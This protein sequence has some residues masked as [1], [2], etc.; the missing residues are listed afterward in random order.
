M[1][2]DER[3]IKYIEN[4]LTSEERIAFELDLG[5]SLELRE[6]FEKY[7]R[8][9]KETDELNG[10]KLNPLYLDSIIPEFRNKLET[11]KSVSIKRNLGYAFGVMLVFIISI[12]VLNDFLNDEGELTE[13]EEFTQSLN[14]NQKIELLEEINLESNDYNIISENI[15]DKELVDILATDMEI[16]SEVA[17]AYDISYNELIAGLSQQKIEKVYSEILNRNF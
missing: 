13:I 10:L 3:I 11:P 5:N 1:M 9:Q 14:E 2:T 7:L 12:A 4:E 16:N 6:A 15:S 17:E 8:V